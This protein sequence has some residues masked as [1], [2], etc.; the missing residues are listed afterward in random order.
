[1]S[2]SRNHTQFWNQVRVVLRGQWLGNLRQSLVIVCV[3]RGKISTCWTYEVQEGIKMRGYK[4]KKFTR[5]QRQERK[6]RK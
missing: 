2:K 1:M 4:K 3:W 6:S 5:G